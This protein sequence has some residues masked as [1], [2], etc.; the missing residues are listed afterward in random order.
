MH[1]SII[2]DARRWVRLLGA[3]RVR[4]PPT[5]VEEQIEPSG[6]AHTSEGVSDTRRKKRGREE[7]AFVAIRINEG[8]RTENFSTG[9]VRAWEKYS[10]PFHF[11]SFEPST[12]C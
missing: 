11:T 12:P 8:K 9:R 5:V 2:R 4:F 1:P 7:R 10:T 3:L 6:K